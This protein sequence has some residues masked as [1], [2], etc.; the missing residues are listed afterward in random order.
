[1]K[2]GIMQPYFFPYIGYFQLLAAVDLF[3]IYDNIKYTKKGWINRNRFLQNGRDA[4]FTLPLKSDSDFLDVV[5]RR[6]AESFDAR[7]LLAQLSQAYR[8]APF[9]E[10][11]Y[12]LIS[13]VL[14]NPERNLFEFLR[15]SIE[16]VCR[17][18]K[19]DTR[20][21]RSSEVQIAPSLKGQEKVLAICQKAGASE[22]INPIGG[23]ELYSLEA[24]AARG[25]AL[26]FLKPTAIEY[27]QFGQP[28]V[29]W[30]SIIDVMMFNS[31]EEIREF[32]ERGYE[33]L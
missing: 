27:F 29:P 33:L 11:V 21:V 20:I 15:Q 22:Y 18:L 1:M 30:L 26:R 28:F 17:H 12:A 10:P 32:L 16:E 13:T 8:K 5:D 31:P 14:A 24:F 25:V 2:L 7:A 9:F 23:Q 19:I 4:V 6:I 3:V